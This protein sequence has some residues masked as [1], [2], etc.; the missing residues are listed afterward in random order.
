MAPSPPGFFWSLS[1]RAASVIKAHFR[2][3]RGYDMTGSDS[4]MA[5]SSSKAWR[6]S[7]GRGPPVQSACLLSSRFSGA[8]IRE[9]F[10]T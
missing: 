5:L 3:C 7:A 4:R 1:P 2:S 9:K 10:F 6:A 8:A